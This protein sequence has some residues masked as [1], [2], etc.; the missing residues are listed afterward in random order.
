MYVSIHPGRHRLSGKIRICVDKFWEKKVWR[1]R[2]SQ[3]I[4]SKIRQ[5]DEAGMN[6][7][8]RKSKLA[9]SSLGKL[10]VLIEP[11]GAEQTP[12]RC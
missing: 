10:Q 9:L 7:A 12:Y 2:N 5:R 11:A 8:Q 4:I 3:K 6:K 1:E